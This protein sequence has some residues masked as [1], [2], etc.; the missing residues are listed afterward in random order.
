MPFAQLVIGPPGCGKSTF[1]DGMHQFLNGIDRKC[2]VVN[3]DPANDRTNYPCALDVRDLVPLEEVMEQEELGPNGGVL[4]ALEELEHNIEWME[5]RLKEIKDDYL[6]IDCPG[7]VELFTHHNSM[8][9]IFHRLEKLGYRLVIVQLLDSHALS[10]PTLWI[11]SLLLTLRSMLH[12]PY[13]LVNVLSK[14]DNLSKAEPLP[15]NLAYYTEVQDLH[16]LL[17]HLEAEQAGV[18][19]TSLAS[20]PTIDP[21][22]V[23]DS[24]R[25]RERP[26]AEK[27][28]R[29]NEALIQLID[30]FGLV[31]FQ[32]LAVEDKASMMSLVRAIDRASGFVFG[33][34]AKGDLSNE[35]G[36]WASA[37]Q[38]DWGQ[39]TIGDVQERWI[40]RREE[41][42]EMERKMWEEEAKMAGANAT[43]S[44]DVV[45]TEGAEEGRV[46]TVA[47]VEAARKQRD[48]ASTQPLAE[49]DDEDLE[50][51][52]EA[53]LKAKSNGQG[54]KGHD[55]GIQVSRKQT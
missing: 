38:E 36:V 16:Y 24:I 55:D 5:E 6:I 48:A 7:Q 28:R 31:S 12:L 8:P 50:A 54:N 27:W 15:F 52:Q 20:D 21:Q 1:C 26:G 34:D 11:S 33:A 40:D 37:M 4:Y 19:L 43:P 9:V 18:S 44:A 14:I 39:M 49:D 45:M 23:L 22:S 46:P 42:D 41:F 47:E 25:A 3:L 51:M 53:Y 30:D 10:Q 35:E 32:P 13:P 29:L 2:S 17:P